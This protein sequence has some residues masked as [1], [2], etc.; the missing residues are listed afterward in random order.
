MINSNLSFIGLL[1]SFCL[2]NQE[3]FSQA[4]GD[5]RTGQTTVSWATATHWQTWNGSQWVTAPNSPGANNDVYIQASHTA[6][7]VADASCNNLFIST[8]TTNATTGGNAELDLTDYVLS[9]NGKVSCYYG[10]VD[11]IAN[12]FS[13]LALTSSTTIPAS[14]ITKTANSTTGRIKFVGNSRS[15]FVTGEWSAENTGAN[16]SYDIEVA[17]NTNQ[18][19]TMEE[20]VKACGWIINSGI[21]DAGS[22]FISADNGSSGQGDI[23]INSG[24]MVISARSSNTTPVMA[25]TGATPCGSIILNTGGLLELKGLNPKIDAVSIIFNGTVKYSRT[26]AQTFVTKGAATGSVDQGTYFN[27]ILGNTG[28]RTL[29]VNTTVNGTMSIQGT[30]S[31]DTGGFTLAYGSSSTLEYKGSA[32]QSIASIPAEWPAVNGPSGLTI[33][34][35]YGVILGATRTINDTLNL[36]SGILSTTSSALITLTATGIVTGASN[37]SFVNGPLRKIGNT[38][39]AFPIGKVDTSQSFSGYQAL[40]ISAPGNINDTFTAEYMRASPYTLGYSVNGLYKVSG[41]EY[42][43]LSRSDTSNIDVSLY[44]NANSGCNGSAG[45]NYFGNGPTYGNIRISWFNDTSATWEIAG[46]GISYT[47]SLPDLVFKT[48]GVRSHG[49]FTFGTTNSSSALPIKLISF[50]ARAEGN[51]IELNWVTATEMNNDHF[52]VEWSADGKCF[53]KFGEVKGKGTTTNISQYSYKDVDILNRLSQILYYRLKQF[54]D[55]GTSGYSKIVSVSFAKQ[56]EV[57]ILDIIPNPF[58]N[59]LTVKYYL[60]QYGNITFSITDAVGHVL[61][62]KEIHSLKGMNSME[63][64]TSTYAKGYYFISISY[65]GISHNYKMAV[66]D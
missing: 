3:S 56:D 62:N 23:S 29:G 49:R 58:D 64:N 33:A 13:S 42:W 32:L 14:P 34:N 8:G 10:T 37:S 46:S 54:D 24:G 9:I 55:S 52:D 39:F 48:T 43:Q 38:A 6:T 40:G 53:C 7:L 4:I 45:N 65:N 21:L 30:T 44:A 22:T 20:N 50:T 59:V 1:I 2:I 26:G 41:C 35:S 57:R 19:A 36:L 66:K 15:I 16:T 60:P 5:Y 31:L 63:I 28:A 61:Q 25:R 47:G 12:S 51:S 11:T 17:L 18:T 27:V